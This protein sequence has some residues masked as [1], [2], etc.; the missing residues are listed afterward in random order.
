MVFHSHYVVTDEITGLVHSLCCYEECNGCEVL[1][2]EP[3]EAIG[4]PADSMENSNKSIRS[5]APLSSQKNSSDRPNSKIKMGNDCMDNAQETLIRTKKPPQKKGPIFKLKLSSDIISEGYRERRRAYKAAMMNQVSLD[6][7]S[8]EYLEIENSTE[9][10]NNVRNN[11]Q[12]SEENSYIVVDDSEDDCMEIDGTEFSKTFNS[13]SDLNLELQSNC[14]SCPSSPTSSSDS[15]IFNTTLQQ[16]RADL[17]P[18][19]STRKPMISLIDKFYSKRYSKINEEA[20][21]S[22]EIFTN[23]PVP[24]TFS[25][26][27]IAVKSHKNE[28]VL[29]KS[30]GTSEFPIDLDKV[31]NAGSPT[32]SNH[33]SQVL[34]ELNP[35]GFKAVNFI[36]NQDNLTINWFDRKDFKKYML[37]TAKRR[38]EELN[39][40]NSHHPKKHIKTF[41][42]SSSSTFQKFQI[43]FFKNPSNLTCALTHDIIFSE[44]RNHGSVVINGDER[45]ELFGDYV[46]SI[47]ISQMVYE[48]FKGELTPDILEKIHEDL[49]SDYRLCRFAKMLKLQDL[50]YARKS[51]LSIKEMADMFIKLLAAIIMD[52]GREFTV[53]FIRKL[54]GPTMENL[55]KDGNF[56]GMQVKEMMNEK[57]PI[58]N[59]I[60]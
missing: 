48:K 54:I 57:I 3:K 25:D 35:M 39:N 40:V 36:Q 44:Q 29:P 58:K 11:A 5:H 13:H 14:E 24:A 10:P 19:E 45:F 34:N 31:D 38:L 15:D 26:S 8:D 59:V 28:K 7:S 42:K 47:T 1:N 16:Q 20:S 18:K 46:L 51:F 32:F 23:V 21:K 22:Q 43:P 37:N 41:E 60:A 9:P 6:Y 2:V 56:V 52:R 30:L 17:E 50:I 12:A 33:E 4:T 53:D 27:D 49:C 55:V